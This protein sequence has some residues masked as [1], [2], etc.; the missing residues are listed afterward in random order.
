VHLEKMQMKLY[1]LSAEVVTCIQSRFSKLGEMLVPV[2]M[3]LLTDYN[4]EYLGLSDGK[5][6]T[7]DAE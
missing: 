7:P 2:S 3:A 4:A 1:S 6:A 5:E